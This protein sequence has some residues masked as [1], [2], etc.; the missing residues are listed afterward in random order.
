MIDSIQKFM[1][2]AFLMINDNYTFLLNLLKN[3]IFGNKKE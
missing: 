1:M 3:N 2:K